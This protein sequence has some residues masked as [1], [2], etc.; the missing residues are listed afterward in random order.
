LFRRLKLKVEI[1]LFFD[2]SQYIATD[3]PS[4]ATRREIGGGDSASM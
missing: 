1:I 3:E 4:V 2:S